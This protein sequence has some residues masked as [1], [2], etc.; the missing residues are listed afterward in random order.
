MILQ[1]KIAL[2][3]VKKEKMIL[4][5]RNLRMTEV[6]TGKNGE[7]SGRCLMVTVAMI[8]V[9]RTVRRVTALPKVEKRID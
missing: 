3:Q 5:G 4:L 2:V 7:E 8:A 9:V 1:F 6:R